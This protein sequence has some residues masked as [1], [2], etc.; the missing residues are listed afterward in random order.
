M[1][2][3]VKINSREHCVEASVQND[4]EVPIT[5]TSACSIPTQETCQDVS[6]GRVSA[7]RRDSSKKSFGP[8]EEWY[9]VCGMKNERENKIGD[10]RGRLT[11][12]ERPAFI[13][14]KLGCYNAGCSCVRQC[15]VPNPN[16]RSTA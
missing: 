8:S 4:C 5:V 10:R 15:S 12:V 11:N 2:D 16:T 14:G 6:L 3:D 9:Y 13:R 1:K 7:P